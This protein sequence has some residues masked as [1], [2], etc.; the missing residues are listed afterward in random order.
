VDI[1]SQAHNPIAELREFWAFVWGREDTPMLGR[2][3]EAAKRAGNGQS[4]PGCR[5][6]AVRSV[7]AAVGR[8]VIGNPVGYVQNMKGVM[9][10]PDS[11]P[12][13]RTLAPLESEWQNPD[14]E[15]WGQFLITGEEP[16]VKGLHY[17]DGRVAYPELGI[18]CAAGERLR[19]AVD[20]NKCQLVGEVFHQA[21]TPA[22]FS[23][24]DFDS[25]PL[26]SA[27]QRAY[28]AARSY[29]QEI[30]RDNLLLIGATGTGKTRLA[31]CILKARP[32]RALPSLFVSASALL[33]K[34]R[35]TFSG[36]GD[37]TQLM[38]T[39]KAVDFLVLDDLGALCATRW[40]G[41][42]LFQALAYRHDR[43]LRMHRGLSVPSLWLQWNRRALQE[44]CMAANRRGDLV[45]GRTR[46][47][48]V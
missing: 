33:D 17:P 18:V 47:H 30:Q 3:G 39:V 26:D 29:F 7:V 41:E 6:L 12:R 5:A 1:I 38:E 8:R 31:V 2:L 19:E 20:P 24:W 16:T 13:A 48:W 35:A 45:R 10:G 42:K 44:S 23:E 37:H 22:V 9:G 27:K 25:F 46:A 14:H 36:H 40:A 43:L 28:D 21:V 34:I 15:D 32:E 11:G 4:R